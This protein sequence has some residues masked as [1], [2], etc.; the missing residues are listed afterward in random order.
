MIARTWHGSV[1]NPKADAYLTHPKRTGL[2]AFPSTPGK[3]GVYVLRRNEVG[4]THLKE[5][6]KG[7]TTITLR[8]ANQKD[9][10]IGFALNWSAT[11]AP[12]APTPLVNPRG[13]SP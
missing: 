9:D 13:T 6:A 12:R 4:I 5:L 2:S 3:M 11:D 10:I 8:I 1:M 7:T